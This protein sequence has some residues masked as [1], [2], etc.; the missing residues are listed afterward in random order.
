LSDSNYVQSS[1]LGGEISP[2]A[3][4]HIDRPDYRIGM[5]VCRNGYPIEEGA[6]L[7]RSGTRFLATTLNGAPGRIIPFDFQQ[8]VPYYLEFTDGNL[9][10]FSTL[11]GATN[12]GLV[13]SVPIATP[14]SGGAWANLRMVQA[15][16]E[17]FLL[18]AKF[19]PRALNVT[20]LPSAIS[21]ASFSLA[22][23]SFIDGPYLDPP[24]DGSTLTPSAKT[25]TIT[26][27]A[28]ALGSINAGRG[29]LSTDVGR[30]VRLFSEPLA[31]N[32]ATAYV[33]GQAVKFIDAYF[34]CTV[35]NTGQQP[36]IAIGFWSI[37]TSVLTWTWGAITAVSS[38]TV[39]SLLIKGVDLLYTGAI[40]VWRLGVYSDTTRWPMCGCYF[41]GR[42]W[43]S[44]AISNRIDGSVVNA[45][46]NGVLDMSPT[47]PDGTVSDNNAISYI[48]NA[49]D[50]N[51]I[52]W[53]LAEK[54]GILCGTQ[55]A[56]W[57]VQASALSDPITPTSIQ[58]HPETDYG[59]ENIEPQRCQNTT[60]FV[61]RYGRTLLEYFPDVFSGRH[62][63]PSLS[64][65]GKHLTQS[66]L[67]EIR[68]QQE[69]LP[70]V[71]A[72]CGNG[73]LIGATYE[74]TS[75]FSSQA[76]SFVAWHRHDLGSGRVVESIAVGSSKDGDFDNLVMVT[77][78]PASGI[79]HVELLQNMFEVDAP[80]AKGW[81][82]DDAV[83]PSSGFIKGSNRNKTLI[84]SGLD[85]LDGKTVTAT[86]GGLDCGDFTVSAGII[87]L[88]V[89]ADQVN[90]NTLTSAYLASLSSQTAWGADGMSITGAAAY[91]VPCVVGFT[92]T[93]QGQ[94]LRPDTV[95]QNRS[96]TG[97]S[98]AK[99]RRGHQ[100]GV[101]LAGAQGVS[102]G[103]DFAKLHA[104]AFK[105]P[106]GK[107]YANTQLF[108][109]VYWDSLDD[110]YGFDSRFAWQVTRPYP[111]ALVSYTVFQ[112]TQ[113]R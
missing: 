73:S 52:F 85:H 98:L 103:T 68:Y 65:N 27:T 66:G 111:C 49:K 34:I 50:V 82:L 75:L 93:S 39:V 16:R 90:P 105:T 113:D 36:D 8:S 64:Q 3:Q 42:I 19:A 69:F 35:N 47:A 12:I 24:G 7:R 112:N 23:A 76:P 99:P 18:H 2:Y 80:I 9:R 89:D 74:R 11:S 30:L 83:T 56:E 25:G 91:T 61:Q 15:E 107:A 53:M 100:F 95:E 72:R 110:D 13:P 41:E 96:Q 48:F 38:T 31:W 94:G 6:W 55:N 51:P 58:A 29:F 60:A 40:A 67:K 104:A 106:G 81:F 102:F 79:R 22:T 46:S 57:F 62:L 54:S 63:A 33:A 77:N 20:A 44:G 78:D 14:Y 108:S 32:G 17:S 88:P 21:Y 5:S 28:S 59:S 71:W 92:Y 43:L 84:L 37:S 97:P 1:F 87:E 101:L 4:G 10:F 70:V 45:I 109:G 86:V 26:L